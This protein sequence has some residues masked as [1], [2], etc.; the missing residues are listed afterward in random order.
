MRRMGGTS[1]VGGCL[2]VGDFWQLPGW[3]QQPVESRRLQS[4][5]FIPNG[6][7]GTQMN[8]QFY[9]GMAD[10]YHLIFED[11]DASMRR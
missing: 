10:H 8:E 3:C 5:N 9:D 1:G 4:A 7:V 11:W 6:P 2:E